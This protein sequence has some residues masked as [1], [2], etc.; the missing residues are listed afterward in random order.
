MKQK[1]NKLAQFKQWI[2][3][4]VISRFIK[5]L[6]KK[7]CSEDGDFI[8]L[9]NEDNNEIDI[10]LLSKDENWLHVNTIGIKKNE[11]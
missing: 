2:L 4:I 7:Y 9:T 8:A 10:W 3:S 11:V 5:Y 6:S 1:T